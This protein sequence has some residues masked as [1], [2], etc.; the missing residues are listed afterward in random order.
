MGVAN[1]LHIEYFE[2]RL[3]FQNLQAI[4]SYRETESSIKDYD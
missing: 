2:R 3:N 1:V 4:R